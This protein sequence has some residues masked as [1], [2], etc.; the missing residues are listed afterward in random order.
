LSYSIRLTLKYG[1]KR[2]PIK[3]K[4]SDPIRKYVQSLQQLGTTIVI[5]TIVEKELYKNLWDALTEVLQLAGLGSKLIPPLL[6][7]AQ[8]NF[9]KLKAKCDVKE[10]SEASIKRVREFYQE[11]WE[12]PSLQFKREIWARLKKKLVSAGPLGGADVLILATALDVK[13]D[14]EFLTLDNDFLVF[15]DEIKETLGI[16]VRDASML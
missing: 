15:A 14:V 1:S 11:I 13:N 10:P 12:C 9:N 16:V 7:S 4:Y 2:I 3:T 6:T 8:N 5:P